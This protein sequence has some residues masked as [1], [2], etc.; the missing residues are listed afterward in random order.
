MSK[1][2]RDTKP[3]VDPIFAVIESHQRA[4]AVYELAAL[5]LNAAAAADACDEGD[6]LREEHDAAADVMPP[7]HIALYDARATTPAGRLALRTYKREI[8]AKGLLENPWTSTWAQTRAIRARLTILCHERPSILPRE[9]KEAMKA[10]QR[11]VDF[12][13]RHEV[14]CDWLFM[15]NIRGLLFMTQDYRRSRSFAAIKGG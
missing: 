12:C 10:D 13:R 4:F 6:A 5:K 2:I 8:D 9:I 1:T 11:L 15:G 14:S 3:D 7:L